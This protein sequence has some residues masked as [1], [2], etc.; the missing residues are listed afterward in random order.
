M[1]SLSV[2]W[3]FADKILFLVTISR[4]Q[5]KIQLLFEQNQQNRSWLI[6]VLPADLPACNDP[7]YRTETAGEEGKHKPTELRTQPPSSISSNDRTDKDAEF[8]H[9]MGI[10]GGDS[11]KSNTVY[12][13]EISRA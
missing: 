4:D 9:G 11:G 12:A 6:E 10:Y 8:D 2:H 13:L 5:T 1:L 3:H 7:D